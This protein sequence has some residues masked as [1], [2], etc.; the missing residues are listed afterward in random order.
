MT[1]RHKYFTT[2][3]A[4]L[5]LLPNLLYKCTLVGNKIIDY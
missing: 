1:T 5:K 3:N 4:F 2:F